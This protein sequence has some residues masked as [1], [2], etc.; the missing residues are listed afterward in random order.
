[1][2]PSAAPRPPPRKDTA[3]NKEAPVIN[4]SFPELPMRKSKNGELEVELRASMSEAESTCSS[5]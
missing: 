1:M 4:D 5:A 3:G 2:T